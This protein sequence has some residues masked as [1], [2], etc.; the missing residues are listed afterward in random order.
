M[1]SA[2]VKARIGMCPAI[3]SS[4]TPALLFESQI[5]K[6]IHRPE[7]LKWREINLCWINSPRFGKVNIFLN[8]FAYRLPFL[9]RARSIVAVITEVLCVIQET[10][11]GQGI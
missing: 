10:G 2:V 11:G 5:A 7:S 8:E 6:S 9:C 4:P 3:S 1:S